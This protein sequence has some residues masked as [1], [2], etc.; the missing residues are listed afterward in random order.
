[1]RSQHKDRGKI[2]D[3]W[4]EPNSKPRVDRLWTGHVG[5]PLT[6]STQVAAEVS[7]S[8]HASSFFFRSELAQE[9]T[10]RRC[11]TCPPTRFAAYAMPNVPTLAPGQ[12][13]DLEES[14]QETSGVTEVAPP[15][16]DNPPSDGNPP[17]A[18][19][20]T[21]SGS[22]AEDVSSAERCDFEEGTEPEETG[23][24]T[25]EDIQKEKEKQMEKELEMPGNNTP[26]VK[27]LMAK[28]G[29]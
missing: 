23:S 5:F 2:V 28:L 8:E 26:D 1:M 12:A 3:C 6:D 20:P 21:R 29:E 18:P 27:G 10:F 22:E 25:E 17:T 14:D 11:G 19:G 13:V 7:Q 9:R 16:D 15:S 4:D 24:T